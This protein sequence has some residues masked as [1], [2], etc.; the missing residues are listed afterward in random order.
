MSDLPPA[1][2]A[3]ARSECWPRHR[4]C[5][6]FRLAGPWGLGPCGSGLGLL[7]CVVGACG[8]GSVAGYLVS[9]RMGCA[10]LAS[11]FDTLRVRSCSVD[12]RGV[13]WAPPW[14]GAWSENA[15]AASSCW[16]LG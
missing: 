7:C 11:F 5:V 12:R 4:G 8:G 10:P 3:S 2:P 16:R 13:I 14:P 6:R 15:L 9:S 1:C